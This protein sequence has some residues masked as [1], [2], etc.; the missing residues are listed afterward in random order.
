MI[1]IHRFLI[2]IILLSV[3][4][5]RYSRHEIVSATSIEEET[6]MISFLSELIEKEQSNAQ[7]YSK[8]SQVYFKMDDYSKALIDIQKA[9]ELE[10]TSP[11][12]YQFQSKIYD[13]QNNHIESINSALQAE[14][15]GLKNYEL[16]RI[17][18]VNYLAINEVENAKQSIDRLMTLNRSAENLCLKADIFLELKDSTEAV[19]SYRQAIKED[20]SLSRP[21]RSLY[22]I[23]KFKDFER[24]EN[25]I[26]EYL[27]ADGSNSDMLLLKARLL[28]NRNSYD[29]SLSF[30]KMT[31]AL[32][33]QENDIL[34]EI[35]QLY[36]ERSDY[37]SAL[38]LTNRV[39]LNDSL[40]RN[41]SLLTARS[42][43]K[44]RK[45]DEAKQVYEKLI[46]Q[47]S[48]DLVVKEELDKLNRKV[49]YLWRLKQQEQ[50]F[51]SLRN[52]T[53]PPT[54][55]RKEVNQ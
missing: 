50:S 12:L 24:A 13:A 38:L 8:R 23:Y 25:I 34:T 51:D 11:D 5:Q 45:Y 35:G 14:Q 41:A 7:I 44:K 3:S 2:I 10:P 39:L 53:A 28:K 29:S 6:E 33:S 27:Q 55:E 30:Y 31:G 47:D 18:A 16:Y 17:L 19:A 15:R 40:Y 42:L 52:N 32:L 54:V 20:P 21:Y 26:D 22:E 1:V 4:C 46:I 36:F 48:T 49:A 43:D 37:D 9:L